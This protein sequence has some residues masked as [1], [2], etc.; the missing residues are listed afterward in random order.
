MYGVQVLTLSPCGFLLYAQTDEDVDLR[1]FTIFL[2]KLFHEDVEYVGQ[3]E[4]QKIYE[5]QYD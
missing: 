5:A 4:E 1:D 2:S 3:I